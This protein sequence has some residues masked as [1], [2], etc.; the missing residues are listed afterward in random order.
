MIGTQS[1]DTCDFYLVVQ[2]YLFSL[3]FDLFPALFNY[4]KVERVLTPLAFNA[5]AIF[6]AASSISRFIALLFMLSSIIA[7]YL[8]IVLFARFKQLLLI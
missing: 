3:V 6:C 8:P 2:L 5:F 7:C 4:S 1:V